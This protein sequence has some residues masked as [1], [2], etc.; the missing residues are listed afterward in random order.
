MVISSIL[1]PNR[2]REAVFDEF[3]SVSFQYERKE[4]FAIFFLLDKY[5]GYLKQI[6]PIGFNDFCVFKCLDILMNI[7]I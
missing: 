3:S 7:D 2:P 4:S 6:I 5:P 1:K